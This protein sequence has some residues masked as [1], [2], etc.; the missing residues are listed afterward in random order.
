MTS[1]K[2]DL[3]KNGQLPEF[4]GKHFEF[5]NYI[6]NEDVFPKEGRVENVLFSK[7]FQLAECQ[8]VI[9]FVLCFY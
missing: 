4:A 9:P 3:S 7:K 2:A 6:P 8:D 5:H 1:W